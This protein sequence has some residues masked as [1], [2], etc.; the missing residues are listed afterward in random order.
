MDENG[1][2]YQNIREKG[3]DNVY[4]ILPG[5]TERKMSPEV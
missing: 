1:C 4:K 5:K 3:G 2:T